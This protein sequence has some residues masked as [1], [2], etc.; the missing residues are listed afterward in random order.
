MRKFIIFSLFLFLAAG[1]SAQ[2]F[3]KPLPKLHKYSLS[4]TDTTTKTGATQNAIRPIVNVA[5]YSVPGNQILT[6]AGV[7]YQHLVYDAVSQKWNSTWS[8]NALGWY[9]SSLTGT[10]PQLFAYGVA[11]GL[12]NNLVLIG[13]AYN[14]KQIVA[15]I[16]I[17]VS[18]N[19]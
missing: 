12:L 2:S 19:N 15:T 14:D 5:S 7:S 10:A 13:G 16:G 18:L 8:I 3:F 1:V 4:S 17:G 9:Q 6:G 11:V